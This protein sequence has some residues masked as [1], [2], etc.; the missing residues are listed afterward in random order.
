MLNKKICQKCSDHCFSWLSEFFEMNWR[1]GGVECPCLGNIYVADFFSSNWVD[2]DGDCPP[3]CYYRLEQSVMNQ[4]K[5]D[6]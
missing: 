1:R 5:I 4:K 3:A 6:G 2:R